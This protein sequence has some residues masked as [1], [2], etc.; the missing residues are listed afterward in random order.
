MKKLLFVVVAISLSINVNAKD[1]LA[2]FDYKTFYSPGDGGIL[3]TYMNFDG[4]S[5]FYTSA[6]EEGMVMAKIEVTIIIK[7]GATSIVDFIKKEVSSPPIR[8]LE[9]VNFIDQNR[10]LLPEGN[11]NI[12]INIK[13]LN[14]KENKSFDFKKTVYVKASESKLFFS[15]VEL[16]SAYRPAAEG[17]A[18]AKSGYD[19][20]PYTS[21]FYSSEFSELLF[22]VEAYNTDKKAGSNKDILMT[23]SI[24]EPSSQ[25]IIGNISTFKKVKSAPVISYLGKLPIDELYSGTYNIII[26]VRDSQNKILET[27]KTKIIRQKT[28]MNQTY[29]EEYI[30]ETFV[31]NMLDRD[32]LIHNINSLRPLCES[33]ELAVITSAEQLDILRLKSFFFSFWLS[34][35][36]DNP[37]SAWNGYQEQLAFVQEKYGTQQKYGFDT[38][39]GTI[40]LKYGPPTSLY[41][42]R[43]PDYSFPFEI[44]HYY[45]S[46]KRFVFYSPQKVGEEYYLLHSNVTGEMQNPKWIPELYRLRGTLRYNDLDIKENQ[47]RMK[48]LYNN[49]R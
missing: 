34:R 15:D 7:K 18:L 28:N 43:E 14:D 47:I 4:T 10:F 40:Y 13:D 37:A 16:I 24:E 45:Q 8:D 12:E 20:L 3:E 32:S 31:G 44:W 6:E 19:L 41:F 2:Y 17:S 25:K 35:N 26:E 48:E 49:P 33:S 21:N 30:D 39:R 11:Y 38:D 1:L 9:Y 42:E 5:V 23:F 22:Y 36:K 27:T 29:D 46:D